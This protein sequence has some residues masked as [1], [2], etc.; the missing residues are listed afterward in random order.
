MG[1]GAIRDGVWRW[2]LYAATWGGTRLAV[3]TQKPTVSKRRTPSGGLYE[4]WFVRPPTGRSGQAVVRSGPRTE[5]RFEFD[6]Q[7]VTADAK[8]EHVLTSV[9]VAT[10]REVLFWTERLKVGAR[11]LHVDV[12]DGETGRLPHH[13]RRIYHGERWLSTVHVEMTAQHVFKVYVTR[14]QK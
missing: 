6:R 13:E 9:G 8:V 11:D 5:L 2:G 3:V 7:G 12:L 4:T 1:T 10:E 14:S